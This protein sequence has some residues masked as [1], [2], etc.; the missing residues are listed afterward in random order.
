M[1]SNTSL[2]GRFAITGVF[3]INSQKHGL[4]QRIQGVSLP[5]HLH[6]HFWTF[7]QLAMRASKLNHSDKSLIFNQEQGQQHQQQP[8]EA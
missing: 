5:A 2:I 6:L 7:N 4:I 8:K 3:D 1:I